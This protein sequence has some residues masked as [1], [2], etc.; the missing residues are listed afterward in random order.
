VFL[1]WWIITACNAVSTLRDQVG[2]EAWQASLFAD[3]RGLWITIMAQGLLSPCR[4]PVS[5]A[6]GHLFGAGAQQDVYENW[7]G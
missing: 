6:A 2:T 3:R 4:W 1:L 7:T 5:R